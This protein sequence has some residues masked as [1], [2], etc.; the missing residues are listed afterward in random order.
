MGAGGLGFSESWGQGGSLLGRAGVSEL[1][2]STARQAC[3][4]DVDPKTW[5]LVAIAVKTH[6]DFQSAQTAP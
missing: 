6:H 3:K 2:H 1:V 5:G 4:I